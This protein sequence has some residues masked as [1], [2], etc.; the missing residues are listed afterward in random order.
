MSEKRSYK[1]LKAHITAECLVVGAAESSLSRVTITDF[2]PN[3]LTLISDIEYA[4]GQDLEFK[5]DLGSALITSLPGQVVRCV[6]I[7]ASRKYDVGV[8]FA[9][10][11]SPSLNKLKNYYS[12]IYYKNQIVDKLR[13]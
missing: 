8:K 6:A 7:G 4:I 1:R 11:E 9:R 3:G 12:Q 10:T 13:G 2:T 5:I